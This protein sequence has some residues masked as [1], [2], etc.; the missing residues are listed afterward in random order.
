MI[1]GILQRYRERLVNSRFEIA[2]FLLLVLVLFAFR[3]AIADWNDVPTGSMEP[4]ILPGDR[5]FVNKLAF[6][7]KVPFTTTHLRRWANP[8]RGD[9]VVLFSPADGKRLVKRIIGTPGDTVAMT[10]N[11][12]TINGMPATYT[13]A[14]RSW[15]DG[16]AST[17]ED[18]YVRILESFD[19]RTHVLT[20]SPFRPAVR[21]FGPVVVPPDRYFV[22]GDNRDC[23]ADSRFFGFV[24][25]EKVVGRACAVVASVDIHNY[26]LPRWSRFFTALT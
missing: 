1:H 14:G 15:S 20:V 17:G 4:T 24:Q 26:F 13:K 25:R 12:L 19:G 8:Q 23:S 3:S 21:S 22:L 9:I 7:L 16:S 11:R 18:S 5:I 6:D 2:R 10:N